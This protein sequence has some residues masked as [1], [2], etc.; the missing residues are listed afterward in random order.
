MLLSF[1]GLMVRNW[2]NLGARCRVSKMTK[3]AD[4]LPR[5][6]GEKGSYSCAQLARIIGRHPNT[7]RKY[8]LW[9]FVGE[10]PR[11][12]NG[13]RAYGRKQALEALFSVTALR[14]CFEDWQGRK[15]MKG[16]IAEAIAGDYLRARADLILH[17]ACL[18]A[19]L[20]E[21]AKARGILEAWMARAPKGRGQAEPEVRPR[22]YRSEAARIVGV[23]P[24]TLRD[25]ERNGLVRPRRLPNG[26]RVYSPEDLERLALVG[27]LRQ[28]DYSLMGIL[29]LFKGR[30]AIQDLGFARDR[31]E[32]T[33]RGLGEDAVLLE[34]ILAELE[35]EPK[36][37]R[38]PRS[39]R[40]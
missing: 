25:W 26:R 10:V 31:W 30:S 32:E 29:Q 8:E 22:V 37:T 28:A 16:A 2:T 38:S 14:T 27:L 3:L 19:K 35:T 4:I 23:A 39:R 11:S 13:Y 20:G 1:M 21:A 24:D 17:R 36:P 12:P 34:E 15:L 6:D 5:A 9:G 40:K 33:L 18:E 7:L